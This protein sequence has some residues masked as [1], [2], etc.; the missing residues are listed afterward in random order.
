M[1][2]RVLV[3]TMLFS[4]VVVV[5][6]R[7]DV[8]RMDAVSSAQVQVSSLRERL[9]AA[10]FASAKSQSLQI[11]DL[12]RNDG[13][14]T[15]S[16]L[17]IMEADR[18]TRA[19]RARLD[20]NIQKDWIALRSDNWQAI[21]Q[22]IYQS[23]EIR[24]Y[25]PDR[26]RPQTRNY[27][28]PVPFF[29]QQSANEVVLFHGNRF[30]KAHFLLDEDGQPY[31]KF[32]TVS[33]IYGPSREVDY[34]Q[35]EDPNVLYVWHQEGVNEDVTYS[36]RERL[37]D[38]IDLRTLE[39]ETLQQ[40]F[41]GRPRF[42]DARDGRL[43]TVT[44]QSLEGAG[45]RRVLHVIELESGKER[46]LKIETEETEPRFIRA[47]LTKNDLLVTLHIKRDEEVDPITGTSPVLH[48][49][50]AYL[51][52]EAIGES[53][54]NVGETLSV[55][56]SR[57][58]GAR[59][60]N[61]RHT[62]GRSSGAQSQMARIIAEPE[63]ERLGIVDDEG[64][65][66]IYDL[67]TLE[68]E[69]TCIEEPPEDNP[70][71]RARFIRNGTAIVLSHAR[72]NA[73]NPL[74]SV[75]TLGEV[76]RQIAELY[77]DDVRIE[78]VLE[79]GSVLDDGSSELLFSTSEGT[80]YTAWLNFESEG[81]SS[82]YTE[83]LSRF[84]LDPV[85]RSAHNAPLTGILDVW[86][87]PSQPSSGDARVLTASRNGQV[88]LWA[89]RN[90]N[91]ND[92][93]PSHDLE[94]PPD[95]WPARYALSLPGQK[96]GFVGENGAGLVDVETG[97]RLGG[98]RFEALGVENPVI[99]SGL[100][101]LSPSGKTLFATQGD[102]RSVTVGKL[103]DGTG[104]TDV[105]QLAV[106]AELDSSYTIAEVGLSEHD[107]FVIVVTTEGRI[108]YFDRQ[109]RSSEQGTEHNLKFIRRPSGGSDENQESASDD[110]FVEEIPLPSLRT[111][112]IIDNPDD[113][114]NAG[115]MFVRVGN[116]LDAF[117]LMLS[118]SDPEYHFDG[119]V[120]EAMLFGA[121]ADVSALIHRYETELKEGRE[122]PFP[123]PNIIRSHFSVKAFEIAPSGEFI[124]ALARL[125]LGGGVLAR[126]ALRGGDLRTALKAFA[127]LRDE[128][129]TQRIEK[130]ATWNSFEDYK[131]DPI[132]AQF[133]QLR[134]DTQLEKVPSNFFRGFALNDADLLISERVSADQS[135]FRDLIMI[136]D[137]R[138]RRLYDATSLQ[139]ITD[140]LPFME[141][142]RT[143]QDLQRSVFFREETPLGSDRP[144][145]RLHVQPLDVFRAPRLDLTA[146]LSPD[147]NLLTALGVGRYASDH[148]VVA[149]AQGKLSVRSIA[150]L[151]YPKLLEQMRR[152]VPNGR[153][154]S[155]EERRLY[156]V[157]D[158]RNELLDEGSSTDTSVEPSWVTRLYVLACRQAAGEGTTDDNC[159]APFR[160]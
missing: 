70:Y 61:E 93:A 96:A 76:C 86:P 115:L 95:L 111:T 3:G 44:R 75:F 60:Q 27:F 153:V 66:S 18:A 22:S 114:T 37:I 136:N 10:N 131:T 120:V 53:L 124:A 148:V 119:S 43:L 5:F 155:D 2:R 68:K 34:F 20:P 156:G 40:R 77:G 121:P 54:E 133:D 8:H 31:S 29:Y 56:L 113:T 84:E 157:S 87:V 90:R 141:T 17:L 23:R 151:S 94:V 13:D 98:V 89:S 97:A 112:R 82:P 146:E 51:I 73:S 38:R 52:G 65:L 103:S 32:E 78:T 55:R 140:D 21:I 12:L 88:S 64:H 33:G 28:R 72:Y 142:S 109:D 139:E 122:K 117:D 4:I 9:E 50:N 42:L 123:S 15:L 105:I 129:A 116:E 14:P 26:S 108:G 46:S 67:R 150:G 149:T 125:R 154:L 99:D 74:L 36:F 126:T 104:V 134:R 128:L 49:F 130:D 30:F 24:R 135:S 101:A 11:R 41:D 80:T 118:D 143:T 83:R 48:V 91:M 106:P 152:F 85:F 1:M 160:L 25:I 7:Q 71:I 79:S 107:R 16:Q 57:F 138:R 81:E 110:E 58:G 63:T 132:S 6:V 19:A 69:N 39:T 102:R 127:R 47:F 159:L 59:S 62:S 45:I 144:V 137:H 35:F 147:Q 100:T 145:L 92:L 158:I